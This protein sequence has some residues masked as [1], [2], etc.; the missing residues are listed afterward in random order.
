MDKTAREILARFWGGSVLARPSHKDDHKDRLAASRRARSRH[1]AARGPRRE[2][3]RRFYRRMYGHKA[4]AEMRR[5]QR[6]AI[7]KGW[8]KSREYEVNGD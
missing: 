1:I 3:W 6:R 8:Y 2:G 7:I 4:L 5:D